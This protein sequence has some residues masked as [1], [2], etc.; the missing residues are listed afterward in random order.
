MVKKKIK[1]WKTDKFDPQ[2]LEA[3]MRLKPS[4]EDCAWFF[5]VH[6][7]TIR[8][9]IR[10]KWGQDFST[11]REQRVVHTRHSLRRELIRQAMA[12]N[13]AALIF[14][15][16]NY[17]NFTDKINNN[18]E[19]KDVTPESNRPILVIEYPK[20]VEQEIREI[21]IEEI[22]VDEPRS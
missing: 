20:P 6:P 16:K 19:T 21:K 14:A 10:I 4:L 1:S 2:Q 12:G 9:Y 11:F 5:K 13:T 22:K 17:D 3:F 15:L 18:V 7:D 8:R